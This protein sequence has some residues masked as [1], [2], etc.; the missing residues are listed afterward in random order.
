MMHVLSEQMS[1][2]ATTQGLHN[3]RITVTE[4]QI[5]DLRAATDE[6]MVGIDAKVAEEVARL[7][8]AQGQ[9][10]LLNMEL[11]KTNDALTERKRPRR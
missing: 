5:I 6:C 8:S 3:E 7:I 10:E 2:V 4:H 11:E 9:I 1:S